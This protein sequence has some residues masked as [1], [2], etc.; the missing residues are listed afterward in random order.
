MTIAP[1]DREQTAERLLRTSAKHTHDPLTEIDWDAPLAENRYFSPPHRSSLYGTALWEGLDEER[2]IELTRHETASIASVGIWFE[3]LL[4][5]M[6]MKHIYDQDP[7]TK[8]VQY[9]LTEIGDETRHSVMFARM[10]EK[11][12]CPAYGPDRIARVLGRGSVLTLRQISGFAGALFVEEVLDALQREA[13][14][15]DSLQPLAREVS[16]I[17]VIEE[18]RHIRYAKQEL[19]RQWTAAGPLARA[20]HR[21]ILGGA[22]YLA[23]TRLIHPG[24]YA[25]VG[26]DPRRA[27]KVAA[28]NP[29]YRRTL[30]WAAGKVVAEMGGLGLIKGPGRLLWRRAGLLG[31][32]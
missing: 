25:A 15:D 23:T 3:C 8:H 30:A 9:A 18:A 20:Y 32:R 29:H 16:R 6:L 10:I 26:L 14:A 12:G 27:R 22:V 4:I 19:A 21:L 13:M 31:G 7:T 17:H 28:G 5:P 1:P 24:V 2:R 11:F